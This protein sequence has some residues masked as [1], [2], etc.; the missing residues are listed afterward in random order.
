MVTTVIMPAANFFYRDRPS[1]NLLSDIHHLLNSL[2]K[3]GVIYQALK[4]IYRVKKLGR[5]AEANVMLH[6]VISNIKNWTVEDTTTVC[7]AAIT[8]AHR[9]RLFITEGDEPIP[10]EIVQMAVRH[11][12][13][14]QDSSTDTAATETG[15]CGAA[16]C[17]HVAQGPGDCSMQ[18]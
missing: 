13:D 9:K 2:K 8:I 11:E 15:T 14:T 17:R 18:G 10:D 3:D 16:A 1:D 7:M 4:V 5:H 6:E 12:L